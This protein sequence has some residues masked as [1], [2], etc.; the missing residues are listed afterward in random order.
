MAQKICDNYD[1]LTPLEKSMFMGEL[2]HA[3]QSCDTLFNL[4]KD[5]IKSGYD[6][7]LF[8]GVS[9][10]IPQDENISHD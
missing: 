8:D 4:A 6:K 1:N 2:V 10:N 3:A 5:L 9:F 7:G